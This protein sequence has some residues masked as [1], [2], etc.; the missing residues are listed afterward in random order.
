MFTLRLKEL[1]VERCN[2]YMPCCS[3]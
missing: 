1:R 2:K 3:G